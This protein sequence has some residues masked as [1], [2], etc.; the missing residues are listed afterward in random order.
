MVERKY[1]WLDS[2]FS[3]IR[4]TKIGSYLHDR[5][6]ESAFRNVMEVSH[7]GCVLKSSNWK[8]SKKLQS[9]FMSQHSLVKNT[10]NEIWVRN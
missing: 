5:V 4:R 9:E 3:V 1:I 7:N 10:F 6:I 2:F 8:L